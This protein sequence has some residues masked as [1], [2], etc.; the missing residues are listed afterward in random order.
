MEL[1]FFDSTVLSAYHAGHNRI[2]QTKV[3]PSEGATTDYVRQVL[4]V[5]GQE[6][7]YRRASGKV[8]SNL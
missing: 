6:L 3:V 2:L 1:V 7:N 5:Y 4:S 8:S